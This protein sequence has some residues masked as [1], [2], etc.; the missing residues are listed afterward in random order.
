MTRKFY[1]SAAVV[2]AMFCSGPNA[3]AQKTTLERVHE[4]QR[5]TAYPQTGHGLYINPAPLSLPESQRGDVLH[6]FELSS[7]RNFAKNKT[8]TSEPKPWL[9]FNP[10][11]A[12]GKG[13][14][15]WRER[16]VK[17][18]KAEE[19]GQTYSFDVTGDE[20]QF[21]TP[22]FD[23]FWKNMP[24]G[25]PRLHC[26]LA[27]DLQE[28]RPKVTEHP[29]YKELVS[30]A[31]QGLNYEINGNPYEAAGKIAS[32]INYM[33]TAY[34][35]TGDKVYSDKMLELFR[36]FLSATSDRNR[37]N[38]DFYAGDVIYILT[39]VFDSCY[40]L[41]SEDERAQAKAIILD[42]AKYHHDEARHG[43][44]ETHIFDNH[45]WQR[46]YREMLQVAFLFADSND[47]AKET[48]EYCYELWTARAPA[49]G[50]NR[51]GMW[52]N[53][54]GYF[55]ANVW[56]LYYV[57]SLFTYVTGS[58]FLKHP[59][60]RNA[61]KALLYTWPVGT[62]AP[63][64]GDQNEKWDVPER[65]RM[66]FVDFLARETKDPYAAWY[67]GHSARTIRSDFDMRLYRMARSYKQYPNERNLPE[68]YDKALW[69]QDTGQFATHS[70]LHNTGRNLYLSFRSSQ[71]GSGSHTLADQNSFNLIFRGVPVYRATGYYLNFSDAHNI[72]SYRHTR[73]CNSI[74]VNG[75]GQP[76]TTRAYGKI[77]RAFNGDNISYAC[78]DASNAYCGISEYPMW[79]KNFKNA[80]IEQTPEYGFGETPL[81]KYRRHIFLLHPY[82]VVI[83]D[84]LE[85]SEPVDWDWLLHSPVK[86]DIDQKHG[87]IRTRNDEKEFTTVAQQ[88]SNLPCTMSQTDEYAVAPN[89][90]KYA[91]KGT[92]DNYVNS[93]HFTAK[94]ADAPANRILTIIKILPDGNDLEKAISRKGNN[95]IYER[96]KINAEMDPDKPAHI[97]ITN[98]RNNATFDLGSGKVEL[99]DRKYNHLEDGSSVLYDLIDGEWI[100]D[101]ISDCQPQPTGKM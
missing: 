72:M 1:F 21:V 26:F 101:E 67:A 27:K 7:D 89:V 62:C 29:E 95:F 6:Q 10:H 73:A 49:S 83:Y 50:F 58:D 48:L 17:N 44:E 59:W 37:F 57:P 4:N 92:E 78:G 91:K 96:W 97:R 81:T 93:W 88:F 41:L 46:T 31:R 63:G 80:G 99:G 43:T 12:L 40:D 11:K 45:F 85:A 20:P 14:W 74:L 94:Y 61:C 98:T 66:A 70:A 79:Q 28:L 3:A 55:N 22:G 19:W 16:K 18:G 42:F 69:M 84:E 13:T 54:D 90:A 68:G 56:T 8:I 34:L 24:K 25:Y 64:F 36:A 100:I 75:I 65:Q 76:F 15:Y 2:L 60:Y 5:E 33:Y 71:F 35:T 23:V 9:M 39:H 32:F 30:R 51:D 77:T 38:N 47:W 86:F 87:I 53:G 52:H 82:T